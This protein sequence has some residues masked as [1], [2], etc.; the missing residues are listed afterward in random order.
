MPITDHPVN[1]FA[2]NNFQPASHRYG[3][4]PY[5]KTHS[6]KFRLGGEKDANNLHKDLYKD[7]AIK[8][9]RACSVYEPNPMFPGMGANMPGGGGG[10]PAIGSTKTSTQINKNADFTRKGWGN[11]AP[12][13]PQ[14]GRH[15]SLTVPGTVN[16]MERA[17]YPLN[18]YN[19]YFKS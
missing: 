7:F 9:F 13:L 8:S 1:I 18:L 5:S 11:W 15:V 17:S 14:T 6:K 19:G 3:S 16:R 12:K 10:Y 4:D 2:L